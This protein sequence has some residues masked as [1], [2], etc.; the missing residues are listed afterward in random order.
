LPGQSKSGSESSKGTGINWPLMRY[1]DV[2]LMLAEAENELNGPTELAKECLRKVRSRAFPAEAQEA[3]VNQYVNALGSKEDFFNAVVD[4]RAWEFGGEGLRKFDLGRWNNYGQ[5]IIETKAALNNIGKAA[6][7]LELENPE[8]AQ[9]SNY[10][11]VLYYKKNGGMVEFLNVKYK[12]EVIPALIVPAEDLGKAGNEEAYA[13]VNYAKALYQKI[14]DPV[15]LEV[16]YAP[17][18]YTE[19]S[20]RGYTDP[21]GIG[22]VPYL[23]PISSTTVAASK[24][25]NNEGYG[26]VTSAN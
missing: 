1:S 14:T 26:L 5:K 7:E 6:W 25:L 4:E 21:T 20:W 8:V 2:L 13:T 15:T 10:A 24:Y 11:P 18:N 3:K 19:Y 9:Y 22:A 12:P 23:L 17:A 16:T